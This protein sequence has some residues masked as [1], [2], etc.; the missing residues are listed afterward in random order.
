[1]QTIPRSKSQSSAH[2]RRD[3]ETALLSQHKCGIHNRSVAHLRRGVPGVPV[4][5]PLVVMQQC[6]P[7]RPRRRAVEVTPSLPPSSGVVEPDWEGVKVDD[8]VGS[9]RTGTFGFL[10]VA[11]LGPLDVLGEDAL[12]VAA[13]IPELVVGEQQRS[14]G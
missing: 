9:Y 12:D 2:V 10:V 1:M 5:V 14:A 3:H 8:Y 6:R 13:E 11:A 4:Q 7:A